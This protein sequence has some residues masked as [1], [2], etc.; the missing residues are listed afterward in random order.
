MIITMLLL[1]IHIIIRD[2]QD[3]K[4]DFILLWEVIKPYLDIRLLLTYGLIWFIVSGWNMIGMFVFRGW[5]QK[6]CITI[7]AILW[8]P[9]TCEKLITIPLSIKLYKKW[10]KKDSEQLNKMLNAIKKESKE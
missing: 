5:L 9:C 1:D 6:V 4:N 10:F 8:L 3:I 7:Q 2:W